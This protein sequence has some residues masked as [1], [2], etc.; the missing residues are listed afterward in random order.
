MLALSTAYIILRPF[1]RPKS[2]TSSLKPKDWELDLSS[3]KFPGAAM[4]K[5]LEPTEKMHP[6]L[7]LQKTM[8]S[9]PKVEPGDQVYC[10]FLEGFMNFT[11]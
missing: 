9:I 8:V 2:S 10:T 1:F 7:K 6:H 11:F 4:G 5:G 3:T